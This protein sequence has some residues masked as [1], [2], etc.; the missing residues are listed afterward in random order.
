MTTY[1]HKKS[2]RH[3]TDEQFS[4][5]TTVDG[6][7]IDKALQESV[8]H[9]NSIPPGDVLSR[10]TE[11]KFAFG[12]QPVRQYASCTTTAGDI[13]YAH[14]FPWLQIANNADL[15]LG[16]AR[17]AQ[18]P[19]T[20][21]AVALETTGHQYNVSNSGPVPYDDPA[22]TADWPG[23]WA[24]WAAAGT[25]IG[26]EDYTTTDGP[27]HGYQYAYTNAWNFNKPAIIDDLMIT[28][29]IDTL[30]FA[31]NA[32]AAF[33]NPAGTVGTD[34]V[35][36]ILMVDNHFSQELRADSEIEIASSR[37]DLRGFKRSYA[38]VATYTDMLPAEPAGA[39][40]DDCVE[41]RWRDLNIPLHENARVRLSI[42][43]PWQKNGVNPSGLT[44]VAGGAEKLTAPFFYCTF[45]GCMT[46]LEELEP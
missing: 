31:G 32:G 7:R 14:H 11:S 8:D 24:D 45:R 19:Y 3:I 29:S 28:L 12:Y 42:V 35:S 6:S 44:Y 18:N 36:V 4:E 43:I 13:Y 37:Y 20:V 16:E 38:N 30:R 21:K 9:V 25:A 46:V 34:V 10:Y 39:Q 40:P 5:K 1:T 2:L 22:N 26:D 33:E 27:D 41:I 15:T 17:D 23:D